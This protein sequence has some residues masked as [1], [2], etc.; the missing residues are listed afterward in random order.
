MIQ[1]SNAMATLRRIVEKVETLTG[2]RGPGRAAAVRQGDI[3]A[4]VAQAVTAAL[5]DAGIFAGVGDPEGSVS[6]KVG[7][8]YRNTAGGAGATLFV[9]ESGGAGPTG[10]VGK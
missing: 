5:A 4:F 3:A 6:A 1:D 2:E 7:A 10:W 8:I 9:K